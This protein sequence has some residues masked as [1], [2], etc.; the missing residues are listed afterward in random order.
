MEC[1]FQMYSLFALE[2][3][4]YDLCSVFIKRLYTILLLCFI[5]LSVFDLHFVVVLLCVLVL[6]D[7]WG[8]L[9]LTLI[10]N[11]YIDRKGAYVCFNWDMRQE[12]VNQKS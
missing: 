1:F 6:S 12:G 3:I 4:Q 5:S 10:M 2:I 11:V 9:P 7:L 8:F